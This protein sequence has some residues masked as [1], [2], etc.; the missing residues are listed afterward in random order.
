MAIKQVTAV[1]AMEEISKGKIITAS[2]NEMQGAWIALADCEDGRVL[3]CAYSGECQAAALFAKKD[4][5]KVKNIT[6]DV[7][8]LNPNNAAVVRRYLKWTGP[9]AQGGKGISIAFS[10]WLGCAGAYAAVPFKLRQARLV[11]VD[12]AAANAD[13][14]KRNFLEAVDTATWGVLELGYKEGYGA[15]AAGLKTEEEIVKALLYG[16][17]MIGFDCSDK[18]D[19]KIEA[20]TSEEVAEKYNQLPE[21]F[22]DA[23]KGSYLEADFKAGGMVVHFEQEVLQRIVL[24]FGEAIMHI[25]YIYNTYLKNTPWEIDFELKLAKPDKLMTPQELYFISNELQRNGIKMASMELDAEK[26]AA[27]E[28]GMHVYGEI[29][30]TLGYRLSLFNADLYISD[31]GSTAK[32]LKGQVCFKAGNALWLAALKVVKA[33]DAQLMEDM[34]KFAGLPEFDG[35]KILPDGE[36]GCAWAKAYSKLL[37]PEA[38]FAGKIKEVLAANAGAYAEE[39]ENTAAAMLKA[40]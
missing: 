9:Q 36:A 40:L 22:R 4:S 26:A 31:I 8:E 1:Q 2:L 28:E 29:A 20:M 15:N 19:S 34:Q 16:Y 38:G 23:L 5:G 13:I 6:V 17:S 11:L 3:T 21:E 32:A 27:D 10:D 39:V 12:Y 35:L 25:Q 33:G 7:M 18:I 30:A 24:E 14:L 37:T